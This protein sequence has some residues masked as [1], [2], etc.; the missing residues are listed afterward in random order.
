[1]FD[2]FIYNA[3]FNGIESSY[4][5]PYYE[6]K[7]IQLYIPQSFIN[8][9]DIINANNSSKKDSNISDEEK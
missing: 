7:N 6:Y 9:D 8:V 4:I 3:T 1:M 5:R 2:D